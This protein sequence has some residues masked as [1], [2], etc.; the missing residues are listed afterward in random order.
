MV[1]AAYGQILPQAVLDVPRHGC[2]NIHASLLP[3]WRGAAPVHRAILAGDRETGVSIMRMDAGLDT[4]PVLLERRMAI[5]GGDTTGT[6]TEKLAR[7]GAEALVDA[8]GR[9]GALQ[10]RPQDSAEATYASKISKAEAVVDW[11]RPAED[12]A[13]QVRAFNPAPGAQSTIRGIRVKIWEASAV[14]DSHSPGEAVISSGQ[15]SVGCGK[16]SLRVELVQR[17][18]GRRVAT[19]EF[20][21]GNPWPDAHFQAK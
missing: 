16:G 14:G 11:S 15:L 1:V 9:L 20:L 7:L 5:A 21:R 13:R 3:R 8:L 12:I 10:A 4:G 19:E 18:G 6:L 17:E 2:I